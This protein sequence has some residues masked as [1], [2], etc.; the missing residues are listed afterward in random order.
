MAA[1]R[2]SAKLLGG[3]M[4]AS[5]ADAV[6]ACYEFKGELGGRAGRAG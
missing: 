3:G 4:K 6:A 1:E 5:D 2:P